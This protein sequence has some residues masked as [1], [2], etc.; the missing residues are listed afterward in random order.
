MYQLL[1]H[2]RKSGLTAFTLYV[3]NGYSGLSF[4]R[5]AVSLMRRHMKDGT[6]E[7][8]VV[9]SADRISRNV[10]DVLT[11][12]D[13]AAECG[14]AV[15]AANG[16]LEAIDDCKKLYAALAAKGGERK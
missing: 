3:D 2:A 15:E 13:Y 4:D 6:I 12:S 9:A 5:P 11:F 10:F 1:Y 16:D 8:V 14:V 7:K